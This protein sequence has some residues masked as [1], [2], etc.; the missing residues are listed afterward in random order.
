M[1]CPKRSVTVSYTIPQISLFSLSNQLFQDW[2]TG[3]RKG[4][5]S[6]MLSSCSVPAPAQALIPWGWA[7]SRGAPP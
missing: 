6:D 5:D 3:G 1:V 4:T 7:V 2:K